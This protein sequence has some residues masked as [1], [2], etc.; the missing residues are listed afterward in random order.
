MKRRTFLPLMAT[1]VA[2]A[3]G[4]EAKSSLDS[5]GTVLV[6]G[7]R[8]FLLGLYHPPARK[9][10]AESLR[11]VKEAGFDVVHAAAK[12]EAL[13]E[14]A[15]HGLQGWCTTG[16]VPDKQRIAALVNRIRNHKALLYWETED[17]PSFIWKK[18]A[19]LRVRPDVIRDTY[20]YLRSLDPAHLVYLNH[21]PTNLVSTLQGYNPGADL[22]A[23]DVY[24]VIPHGIREQFALWPDGRQGDMLNPYISQVGA[25]TR[26]MREVAGPQ[27][28]V[29]M[30]QQAFAWELL[31]KP[32]DRDPKMVLYP[33]ADQLRFMAFQSIVNGA[34]GLLWWGLSFTPETAPLWNGLA[35]VAKLLHSIHDELAAPR[36]IQ[37]IRLEYHDT[38][39]SLDR[40][41][42]W[43]AKKN[44]WMAVNADP[45]PVEVT[46][47]GLPPGMQALAGAKP[48]WTGGGWRV[49][50]PPFGDA[51]WRG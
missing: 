46:V 27:R 40:G 37:A 44:I 45:N 6:D 48:E 41:I 16:L 39:H 9:T 28:A 35:A 19:A 21:A 32:N 14:L 10:R 34:N 3:W 18:P 31:R 1:A 33:T 49:K 26:K 38:G 8:T 23:T 7:K 20:A 5:D 24:P 29:L 43:I 4:A 22:I 47:Q 15:Q 36:S 11:A 42:E 13:D 25:Y 30:V 12:P 50:F 17:E 2:P 51:L